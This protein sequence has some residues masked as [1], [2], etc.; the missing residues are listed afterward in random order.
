[1]L[2]SSVGIQSKAQLDYWSTSESHVGTRDQR[3]AFRRNQELLDIVVHPWWTPTGTPAPKHRTQRLVWDGQ[4]CYQHNVEQSPSESMVVFHQSRDELDV[5]ITRGWPAIRLFGVLPGDLQSAVDIVGVS[6]ASPSGRPVTTERSVPGRGHYKIVHDPSRGNCLV[7][8]VV[9]KGPSDAWYEGQLSSQ[10][11]Q[12]GSPVASLRVRVEVD[13]L[14]LVAGTWF[15]KSGSYHV[16]REYA[17]QTRSLTTVR[18]AI[19]RI[20]ASCKLVAEQLEPRIENGTPVFRENAF[21]GGREVWLNGSVVP[22]IDEEAVAALDRVVT[23]VSTGAMAPDRVQRATPLDN[24]CGLYCLY[25]CL[26]LLGRSI[27]YPDL[28]RTDTLSATEGSSFHQLLLEAE[29]HGLSGVAV[30]QLDVLALQD[31]ARPAILH[32]KGRDRATEFAHYV[33]AVPSSGDEVKLIEPPGGIKSVTLGELRARWDGQAILFEPSDH[34]VSASNT[35]KVV[36]WIGVLG[37]LAAV[38]GLT[39]LLLSRS[40]RSYDAVPSLRRSLLQALPLFIAAAT[41]GLCSQASNTSG[42]LGKNNG[43]DAVASRH[44]SAWLPRTTTAELKSRV[45]AGTEEILLVD[46]RSPKDYVSGHI[47]GAVNLPENATREEARALLARVTNSTTIIV[48]CKSDGCRYNQKVARLLY[49]AGH[50]QLEL[51]DEGWDE[52]RADS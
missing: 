33:V 8:A 24:Q 3:V 31:L 19:Q 47:P 37:V 17:D 16:E 34:V 9:Q 50:E 46:A 4:R 21:G 12:A 2:P 23:T 30:K 14:Q 32:V 10:R 22:Y 11:N 26:R 29:R 45:L 48:Y 51:Y 7:S 41:V 39:H 49:E 20:D 36:G 44:L 5:F 52:W 6:S 13:N 43:R 28:V 35:R 42:L 15:P 27:Q 25:A 1:M 38:S 40:T 18:V